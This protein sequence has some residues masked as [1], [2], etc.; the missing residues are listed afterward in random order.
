MRALIKRILKSFDVAI[1]TASP[2]RRELIARIPVIRPIF[3]RP[4]VQ[5]LTLSDAELTATV[6]ARLKGEWASAKTQL[7]V[8][9]FD[10][11]VGKDGVSFGKPQNR[12]AA[13]KCFEALCGGTHC[14]VTAVYFAIGKKIIE[15]SQKT[16]VTFGAFNKEIVYNYIDSG[17]PYDK[18]GGYNIDDAMIKPLITRVDGDYYNVVGLPI[19][20]L[21]KLI[22]EYL[23][24]GKDGYSY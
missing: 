3:M 18:A 1:A 6:N 15:K 20:L 7:P 8:L 17:A 5:E 2:R 14:V 21:E 19:T 10:T 16:S 9:S 13:I 12:E 24:H 22:E 4:D 11:V 23:I